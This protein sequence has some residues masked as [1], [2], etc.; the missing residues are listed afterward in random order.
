MAVLN[1][2]AKIFQVA[3][4][5]KH[6]IPYC[7]IGINLAGVVAGIIAIQLFERTRR[8]KLLISTMTLMFFDLILFFV[9]IELIP[10]FKW[11]S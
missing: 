8:R 5:G 3:G 11:A 1:Y 9:M 2:S 7:V 4:I 6:A 10:M